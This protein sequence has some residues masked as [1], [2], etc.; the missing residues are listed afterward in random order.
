[1]IREYRY[2]SETADLLTSLSYLSIARLV[3]NNN[4]PDFKFA[5]TAATQALDVYTTCL[6]ADSE[7]AIEAAKSVRAFKKQ[8]NK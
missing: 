3:A 8:I 1:M 7:K 5:V 4:P 6:G 2:S